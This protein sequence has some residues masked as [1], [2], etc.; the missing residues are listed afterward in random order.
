VTRP[1]R[2]AVQAYTTESAAAWRE[3]ARVVETLGYSTLHLADHYI[4]PGPA[5]A[6][7]NHPVQ[8][9]AAVPAMA[10]A[11]EATTTLRVGCRVFCVDYHEPVVL[12]KELATLD[13]LSGGRI[14]AGLGAG[15]LAGEY[16][17][18]GIPFAAAGVRI[19]RLRAVV[20]LLRQ[21]AADGEVKLDQGGVFAQGFEAVPKPLQ[22]GGVPIMIGGGSRRV[23]QLAGAEADIVSLNFDNSSGRVGVDGVGSSTAERTAAKLA[24]VREGAGERFDQLEL[25]IGAYFVAVTDDPDAALRRLSGMFDLPPVELERHPHVLVGSVGAICDELARRREEYGISYVTVGA[26]VAADFA[27]VVSRL[28]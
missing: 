15:W 18:M 17:A 19:D 5:L 13:L 16:E 12:A 26:S 7:T 4:G 22:P 25:E 24:W 1:F 27:P 21:C 9:I 10:V 14:E 11:A 28:G 20:D 3:T 2:F 6:A 8:S 23:L